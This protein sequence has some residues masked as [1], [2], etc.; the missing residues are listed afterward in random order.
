M[1]KLAA[2][3]NL[4]EAIK[5]ELTEKVLTTP[6]KYEEITQWLY[7]QHNITTSKPSVCRFSQ[8]V[9]KKHSG[10]VAMGIPTKVIAAEANNLETLGFLLVQRE[11]LNQRIDVVMAEIHNET[12]DGSRAT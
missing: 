12:A 2:L 11:L 7:E 1:S 6:G 5:A 8:S 4:P 9:R 3:D 10:L